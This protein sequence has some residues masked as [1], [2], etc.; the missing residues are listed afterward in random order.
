MNVAQLLV[1]CL[2][3]EGVKYIFGIPGEE[4]LDIMDAL[5]ESSIQFITVRHEQGAAFMADA[6]GRLTGHAGVCLSTLGPG[7]TNLVTGVTDANSDG[8]PLVAIT[9]QVATDKLHI[10]AHQYLD[11][12][13]MFAPITKRTKEVLNPETEEEIVRLAFK[14]AENEIPGATHIT[15]PVDVAKKPVSDDDVPLSRVP[16][17][18]RESADKTSILEASDFIRKAKRPVI[19]VGN[20]AIRASAAEALARF[21]QTVHIPVINTMMAKGILSCDDPYYCCTVGIPLKDYGNII[22]E[23]ADTVIAIGYDIVEFDPHNWNAKRNTTIIHIASMPADINKYY[24]TTTQ[25]VGYIPES[26]DE[27]TYLLSRTTK[28]SLW[29]LKIKDAATADEECYK[30]DL[31]FPMKPQRILKDVRKIMGE[32][33][34]AVADVGAHKMWVAR[35][36]PCYRPNTCLISNG[37]AAMG[38][39]LPGAIAAKLVYPKRKVLAITGDGGF[40]MNVQELETAVRL[41][42]AIVVLIFHDS[43]YGLIKWKQMD[44]FG[45][46]CYVD[47]DNPDFVLLAES[48]HAKGYK[49]TKAEELVPILQ[50]A[51]TQEVPCLIDCPVDYEENLKL[52]AHLKKVYE[53]YQAGELEGCK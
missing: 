6:Y 14:Y 38:F 25:V 15:I 39:A 40:L 12:N 7:A 28:D 29:A 47:F 44:H 1:K 43:S 17:V 24:Q 2:E 4:V 32:E 49:V 30:D 20:G 45:R 18:L 8:A 21:V 5:Q 46:S 31:S 23:Q 10:T 13:R 26:L 53:T 9:G 34:I 35:E 19:L 11:L 27:L 41:H 51:F 42:L 22:L 3:K 36:Y 33:D 50:D 48:F 37:F 16:I 52:S